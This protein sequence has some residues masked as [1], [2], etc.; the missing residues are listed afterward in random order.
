MIDARRDR[1]Y[2]GIYTWKDGKIKIVMEPDVLDI[3]HLL[4]IL[5]KSYDKSTSKWRWI[6]VT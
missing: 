1:V 5:N 2:T 3:Y 4:D 6:H